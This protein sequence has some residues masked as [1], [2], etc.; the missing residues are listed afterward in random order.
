MFMTS[1]L[2]FTSMAPATALAA[3]EEVVAVE[4]AEEATEEVVEEEGVVGEA[5]VLEEEDSTEEVAEETEAVET[6]AEVEV[7]DEELVGVSEDA[8]ELSHGV[9]GVGDLES[10]YANATI[11]W[12]YMSDKTLVLEAK[13]QSRDMQDYASYA[14]TPW[15]KR[16]L[17]IRAVEVQGEVN[18]IGNHAFET[19]N[20]EKV[21]LSY[22]VLKVGE[23]AFADCESLKNVEF[24]DPTK[25]MI[26]EYDDSAFENCVNLV[27]ITFTKDLQY[28]NRKAF[29]NCEKLAVELSFDTNLKAIL[30]GAFWGC[31]AIKSLFVPYSVLSIGGEAVGG[32]TTS[33]AA[34]SDEPETKL[35]AFANCTGLKEITF[36]EPMNGEGIK[37]IGDFAFYGCTSLPNIELPTTL[38]NLGDYAFSNCTSLSTAVVNDTDGT[39]RLYGTFSRCTSLAK[40]TL[41]TWTW[42]D[43][44]LEDYGWYN[45]NISTIGFEAFMDCTSLKKVILSPVK[46]IECKSIGDSAFW[47]C[48]SLKKFDMPAWIESIG[49][50]AF[51][52]CYILDDVEVPD[53]VEEIGDNAFYNCVGMSNILLPVSL[54]NGGI[55]AKCVTCDDNRKMTLVDVYFRGGD[56]TGSDWEKVQSATDDSNTLLK[57][58]YETIKANLYPYTEEIIYVDTYSEDDPSIKVSYEYNEVN[59]HIPVDVKANY[60]KSEVDESAD[61]VIVGWSKVEGGQRYE[62]YQ[63]H[64]GTSTV[65]KQMDTIVPVWTMVKGVPVLKYDPLISTLV[66]GDLYNWRV[67]ARIDSTYYSKLSERETYQIPANSADVPVEALTFDQ[68]EYDVTVGK[69][70][71]VNLGITPSNASATTFSWATSDAG[72]ATAG[73][74]LDGKSATI[75]GVAVGTTTITVTSANGKKATFTINVKPVGT[76]EVTAITLDKTA[77][78]VGVGYSAN[79]VANITPTDADTR[80]TWKSGN[81]DVVKVT[82]LDDGKSAVINGLEEGEAVITVTSSNGVKATCNVTITAAQSD[83]VEAFVDRI[84]SVWL[85]RSANSKDTADWTSKLKSGE[86]SGAM[87]AEYFVFSKESMD[88]NRTNEDFIDDL[89]KLLMNRNPADDPTGYAYW[90]G[91]MENGMSKYQVVA[92][93][94]ASPEYTSICQSYGITRGDIDMDTIGQ[95]QQFVD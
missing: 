18:N 72:V 11:Q 24:N 12:K 9:C 82:P 48:Q 58:P 45:S 62:I 46:M 49:N 74:A 81:N 87:V 5:A 35:G 66:R 68:G 13:G 55:G 79:L 22:Y 25:A 1:V 95:V 57:A 51:R 39:I 14:D 80:L 31:K 71:D 92:S 91:Q 89:Y 19:S 76:S 30:P 50:N 53:Q 73:P 23:F 65:E 7:E 90:K 64:Q 93:F 63:N 32:M 61:C 43:P 42:N 69:D 83:Q 56:G 41:G 86:W 6:E 37:N 27:T 8:R 15:G 3:E 20:V 94:I 47:R 34:S 44:D 38:Y 16:E 77:V 26:Q 78:T 28:I 33:E 2:T 40:V 10:D 75:H 67:R 29:Y 70:I 52:N 21:E 54:K 88:M 17:D 84:Y 4:V 85:E 36:Q 59:P 60:S